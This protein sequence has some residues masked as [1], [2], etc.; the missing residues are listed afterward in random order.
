LSG[1]TAIVGAYNDDGGKGS[2]Y[3]YA[4]NGMSW[5]KQAKLT[6][7]DAAGGDN[8]GFSVALSGNTAIVGAFRDDGGKGS[9]Y[10]FVFNGMT[11]EQQEKLVAND[12]AM[13][14]SFGVSVALDGDTAI[15]GA[16]SDDDDDAGSNAG[17]AYVLTL[18]SYRH[19]W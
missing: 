12:A 9:A 4:F 15:F 10:M 8:F 7:D 2:A 18:C 6:A 1:N 17:S 16:P 19:R 5:E 14:D 13:G 11:W 3:V